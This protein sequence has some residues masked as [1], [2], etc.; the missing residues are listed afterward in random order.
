MEEAEPSPCRGCRGK[1]D[2]LRTVPLSQEGSHSNLWLPSFF[3]FPLSSIVVQPWRLFGQQ[4]VQ[5][6]RHFRPGG[7]GQRSKLSVVAA[8]NTGFYKQLHGFLRPGIDLP[9]IGEVGERLAGMACRQLADDLEGVV[10]QG[11][12]FLAGNLFTRREHVVAYPCRYSEAFCRCKVAGVPGVARIGKVVGRVC[13]RQDAV[14]PH[15]QHNE[16]GA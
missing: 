15:H 5:H 11:E 1:C 8:D 7:R 13:I 9:G 12:H 4:A 16:F 14:C 2:K 10:Q 6:L 3:V